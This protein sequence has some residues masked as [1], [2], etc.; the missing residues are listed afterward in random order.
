MLAFSSSSFDNDD[1]CASG[2]GRGRPLMRSRNAIPRA[3]AM[4][5]AKDFV[6]LAC[7]N[8]RVNFMDAT[9]TRTIRSYDLNTTNNDED[10][11]GTNGAAS[12]SSSSSC[13][14]EVLRMSHDGRF[15]AAASRD[16]L[17]VFST[18]DSFAIVQ[19]VRLQARQLSE[20][21]FAPSSS[22]S[23]PCSLSPSTSAVQSPMTATLRAVPCVKA[24]CFSPDC[25]RVAV[26]LPNV[27]RTQVLCVATG[28]VVAD[29]G[30][31][32]TAPT[33]A[34]LDDFLREHFAELWR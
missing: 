33:D 4:V 10:A 18:A 21:V 28:R 3:H 19:T 24:C 9:M 29:L 11:D 6:C 34:S 16:M 32:P 2:S 30:G 5:V 31:L 12:S 27:R 13:C 25:A 26:S 15:V 8:M 22:A 17:Y 20:S 7:K 23:T 1:S 14:A